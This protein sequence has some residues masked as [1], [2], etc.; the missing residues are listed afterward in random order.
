MFNIG[1]DFDNTLV[2]YDT[3]FYELALEKGLICSDLQ[4][5]KNAVRNSLREQDKD[6]E[7]TLLQGEIYGPRILESKPAHS[8]I[9]TIK[10]IQECG[11]N[12]F[13][14]SHKTRYPYKGPKFDLHESARKWLDYYSFLSFD[15]ANIAE[16]KIFFNTSKIEKIDK[17]HNLKCDF[18]I[19]DLP[20]ILDLIMPDIKK[21]LFNKSYPE[22]ESKYDFVSTDWNLIGE[23]LYKFL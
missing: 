10:K 15:G 3:S 1:I 9:K 23:F 14:V 2:N 12:V 16:D 7:F 20:E 4:K 21:I 6:N 13:I 18:F 11:F 5:S 22:F 8:A 17:V 19:D